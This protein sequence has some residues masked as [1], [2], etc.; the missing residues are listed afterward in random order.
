M[1][2]SH[3]NLLLAA[4]AT[5]AILTIAPV[6]DANEPSG[7][8]S[9]Q[10]HPLLAHMPERFRRTA[11]V[12]PMYAPPLMVV[13]ADDGLPVTSASLALMSDSGPFENT[14]ATHE[15]RGR[16]RFAPLEQ[17]RSKSRTMTTQSL[18]LLVTAPGF[19]PETTSIVLNERA[20]LPGEMTV[21]LGRG[22]PVTLEITREDGQPLPQ[23]LEPIIAD[24]DTLEAIWC[25]LGWQTGPL[26]FGL[27]PVRRMA[28]NRWEF[29]AKPGQHEVFV[30]VDEP[31]LLRHFVAGPLNVEDGTTAS[32]IVRLPKACAITAR[33]RPAEGVARPAYRRCTL[34]V[35]RSVDVPGG[36]PS[37]YGTTVAS[38]TGEG[39]TVEHVFDDLAP[40][41]DDS[42]YWVQAMTDPHPAEGLD[43][44][45]AFSGGDSPDFGNGTSATVEILYKPLSIRQVQG[46]LTAVVRV[47][48]AKGEPAAGKPFELLWHPRNYPEVTLTSGTIPT[49][50]VVEFPGLGGAPEKVMTIAEAQKS[51]WEP[52]HL[53]FVLDGESA[54]MIRFFQ[55]DEKA[56]V[57]RPAVD[58]NRRVFEFRVP[59][60]PGD[61]TPDIE[62]T[63]LADG[64]VF[65]LSDLRDQVIYLDFW[66]TWCGPCQRPM[67]ELDDL[68]R[69]RAAEWTGKVSL[70]GVSIDETTEVVVRHLEKNGWTAARQAWCHPVSGSTGRASAQVKAFQVT[71]YPTAF[72]IG[73][74]GKLIWTGYPGPE[75]ESIIEK[76]LGSR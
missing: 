75:I 52:A 36:K 55:V 31:G 24:R 26:R 60:R 67:H 69:R 12:V 42:G 40:P 64:R 32:L 51:G 72:L 37:N 13:A 15:G 30:I 46:G 10:V 19:V 1:R 41:T 23:T 7:D 8:P 49:S 66:A 20:P 25:T 73:A 28:P 63:D 34:A 22:R 4:L 59:L 61:E 33:F 76:A 71:G 16:Y 65:R 48:N 47:T 56:G 6:A 29:G 58:D 57:V 21:R 53:E 18:S 17:I 74:D 38:F 14:S 2:K 27:Y 50:G 11:E 35:T 70:I 45:Y 62:L 3:R 44:K 54:G 68:A 39:P 5:L 9:A 43:G